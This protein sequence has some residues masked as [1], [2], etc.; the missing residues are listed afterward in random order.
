MVNSSPFS[1]PV[2]DETDSVVLKRYANFGGAFGR[3]SA[4]QLFYWL[5]E[6]HSFLSPRKNREG[7]SG[8]W[9]LHVG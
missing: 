4:A 2:K 8:G 7:K 6:E 9:G 5:R 3:G 1:S